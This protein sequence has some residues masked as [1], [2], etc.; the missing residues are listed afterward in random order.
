MYT[1]Q[2][3]NAR[4]GRMTLRICTAFNGLLLIVICA[5]LWVFAARANSHGIPPNTSLGFRSQHTLASLHGWY[6]AQRVGFHFAAVADTFVTATVFAITAVAY[7]RRWNPMWILIIP[8]VGG[9]A[10]ALCFMIAGHYADHAAIS[11]EKPKAEPQL[12][13][14]L[15]S[16]PTSVEFSRT[17]VRLPVQI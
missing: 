17:S 2:T 9:F 5:G 15:G 16:R 13:I 8:A 12:G 14:E 7:V 6:A 10:V 4:Y 11:V 1:E 3:P